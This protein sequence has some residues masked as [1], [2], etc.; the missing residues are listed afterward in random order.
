[1]EFFPHN[2]TLPSHTLRD[3]L[4]DNLHRLVDLLQTQLTNGDLPP[5]QGLRDLHDI[6]HQYWRPAPRVGTTPTD[7]KSKQSPQ[8]SDDTP[9]RVKR[10][11]AVPRTGRTRST[12][13]YDIGTI[14]R[15][16]F[17]NH[18]HYEGEITAYDPINQ[19]YRIQYLDGD[20]EDF[21]PAEV[22]RYYHI[23][24]RYTQQHKAHAAGGTIWDPELNKMCHY[25]DLIK[26]HNPV[27]RLRW[28]KSGEKE[29]GRLCQGYGEEKGMDVIQ[30]IPK[31]EMP[32]HKKATYPRY[33]VAFRPEK[34]DPYRTRITAGGDKLE[35]Y[36]DVTTH[37]A[38]MEAFKILS[39][40][41]V[42]TPGAKCCTAD[43]SN[44]YLC[45]DLDTPEY[46]KFKASMIPPSIIDHY[47]LTPLIQ[48][49]YIYAK[50]NKAW[51]GLKQSGKIA[52]DDLVQQLAKHGYHKSLYT[53]GLF[54]HSTRK[55][56]FTLVVDDFAIKYIN[57]EDVDHLINCIKER[58][59]V[60][61]DWDAKQYIGINLTWDYNDRT[62]LLS[63][64]D[65]V[66]EALAQFEHEV[67]KQF[68]KAPS[69]VDPI[70]YGAKIQY[71]KPVDSTPITEAELKFIQKVTGKFIFYA[72][73]VDPTMLHA[74][75]CIACG[76]ATKR[77]LEATHHFLNYAACNP[78][79]KI[80]YTASPMILQGDSDAAYLVCPEARSRL[81]GYLF[82][83]NQERTLFNGP[84]IVLAKV[85][86]NVMASAAEAEVAALFT[87]AQEALPMRQCLIELGHPQPATPIKTDNST[88]TGIINNTIKQKRS[89]AMDMRFYW[90]RD[91]VKQGHFDIYWEPGNN[92]L[93]DLPTKH[94][95]GAHHKRLRPIYVFDPINTPK[96]IQG[97]IKLLSSTKTK[98][99][100][101][102]GLEKHKMDTLKGTT[103]G[104]IRSQTTK[105]NRMSPR[106]I[107][108]KT[109][110]KED[111]QSPH[112]IQ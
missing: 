103:Q 23:A 110:Q 34:E 15:K 40:S 50:S 17:P 81:G 97:C 71:A 39:N 38:G 68:Y 19:L 6:L 13:L 105:F 43:I 55:I 65:Y 104:T 94:H 24:Q 51:Y 93:A 3:Q 99:T 101:I 75:N 56:A 112:N 1:M 76:G 89:K 88:A 98:R 9:P 20:A 106:L 91:R 62:V 37:V 28:T 108:R 66:K 45:S 102:T 52:H 32:P 109:T 48:D 12:R 61:I 69:K 25:R 92:N 16:R 59:P 18:K 35:Y 82:L 49:G 27:I 36:G 33:T 100:N 44:M 86:K 77:N 73:A 2:L 58:Y 21:T 7:P 83:G 72:R 85:I 60:K 47:N 10:T 14:I 42:S 84:L 53:E 80:R 67:P 31:N 78:H 111:A 79:S 11:D 29:F 26:H 64:D 46:V 41:I 74:L 87:N 96:S 70:K 22:K 95:S 107:Y 4:E 5:S 8:A 30:W 57:R 63:M 90:L 54:T